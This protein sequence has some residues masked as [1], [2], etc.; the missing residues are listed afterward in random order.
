MNLIALE[1][2][3]I[4]LGYVAVSVIAQRKFSNV[5][6]I[7]EIRTEMNEK[8]AKIKKM[9]KNTSRE[10]MD[11]EQKQVAALTSEMMKHQLK[12]SLIIL[13]VFVVLVYIALPY[14]FASQPFNFALMGLQFTYRTF[15]VGASFVLGLA[16][17]AALAL[18]DKAAAKKAAATTE[19]QLPANH[20]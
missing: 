4:A 1:L 13:P 9:D 14:E 7:K 19:T 8:M 10:I 20:I 17:Q 15:F 12:A 2:V 6:R 5:K 3:L 11:A 18:Y 16:S